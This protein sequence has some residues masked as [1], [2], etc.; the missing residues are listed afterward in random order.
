MNVP[1]A[2]SSVS[3]YKNKGSVKSPNPRFKSCI[4]DLFSLGLA[5]TNDAVAWFPLPAL[6]QDLNALKPL[7][8]TT[9]P[10][11]CGRPF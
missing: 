9:L 4:G 8:H 10:T 11:E 2:D 3:R 1:Q 5:Q 7:Q 6:A